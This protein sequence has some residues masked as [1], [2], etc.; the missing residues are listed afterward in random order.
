MYMV[1]V[2]RPDDQPNFNLFRPHH[3]CTL[4]YAY[5][6]CSFLQITTTSVLKID[7]R[8]RYQNMRDKTFNE[9]YILHRRNL[10]NTEKNFTA[11]MF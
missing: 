10:I 9:N 1:W 11:V 4:Q 7:K 5:L 8:N 3:P 6:I 2:P